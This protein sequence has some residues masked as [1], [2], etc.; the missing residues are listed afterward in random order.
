MLL[1]TWYSYRLASATCVRGA[2]AE[3][4]AKDGKRCHRLEISIEG[5]VL[6]TQSHPNSNNLGYA[7]NPNVVAPIPTPR[8]PGLGFQNKSHPNRLLRSTTYVGI[9]GQ[10]LHSTIYVGIQ[11]QLLHV[12][13]LT[14]G[15]ART[16]HKY[17]HLLVSGLCT[18][19]SRA[20]RLAALK[21]EVL[22][23]RLCCTGAWSRGARASLPHHDKLCKA[24]LPLPM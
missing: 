19:G 11:G 18:K 12:L 3:H 1:Y 5:I 2:G 8:M 15:G 13:E 7:F 10:L 20:T 4:D 21:A 17:E 22:R 24:G 9:Q 6:K 16:F 14:W 23:S